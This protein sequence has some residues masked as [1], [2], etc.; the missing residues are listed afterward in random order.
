MY[1][2]DKKG[3]VLT[4]DAVFATLVVLVAFLITYTAVEKIWHARI[5]ANKEIKRYHEALAI[6][7]YL[8]KDALAFSNGDIV[9][10][11]EIDS[12]NLSKARISGI[13]KTSG[14]RIDVFRKGEI[15]TTD[16]EKTCVRRVVVV[17]EKIEAIT[18]CVYG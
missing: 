14:Y 10:Q 2:C 18:L 16:K 7:D 9:F 5:Y 11:H 4:T 17:D 6:A 15:I 1:K 8:V 3:Q 13:E 12:R